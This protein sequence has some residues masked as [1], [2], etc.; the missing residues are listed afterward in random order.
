[1]QGNMKCKWINHK[2]KFLSVLQRVEQSKVAQLR[3][4]PERSNIPLAAER[5]E[6]PGIAASQMRQRFVLSW[7]R[8]KLLIQWL[9]FNLQL[10]R[11]ED[12]IIE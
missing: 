11:Y 10:E 2:N 12:L 7:K 3:Q 1:M 9:G 8:N 5:H 4:V 6:I